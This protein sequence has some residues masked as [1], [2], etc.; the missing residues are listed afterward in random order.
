MQLYIIRHAQSSNNALADQ[1]HR[2]ADP[3][4]TETGHRQAE[5]LA[6]HLAAGEGNTTGGR[7]G[8]GRLYCSPM[9]RALQTALPVSRALG[10]APEVWIEIHEYGG[11]WQE[12]AGG[13]GARGYPG[14]SRQEIAAEFPGYALP[15]GVSERGWWR[16]AQEEPETFVA[17]AAWVVD[18]LHSWAESDQRAAIITHG[19]FIDGLLNTLLKVA[20]AE[21]VYYHHDN[22]GITLI[23]FRRNG[24]LSIRFLNRLDHLPAELITS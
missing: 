1:R 24:K 22:T 13:G 4:L 2:V 3:L 6:E 19:A 15:E 14:M 10:L 20:R 11:V 8:I 9:R 21:P 18:T 5:L 12:S 17:R 23:D 7:L 16:G